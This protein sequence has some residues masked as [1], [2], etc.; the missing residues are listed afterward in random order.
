[1]YLRNRSTHCNLWFEFCKNVLCVRENV[2]ELV[3]KGIAHFPPA[4][5]ILYFLY[6]CLDVE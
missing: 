6:L 5:L 2:N 3:A 1:M 4:R